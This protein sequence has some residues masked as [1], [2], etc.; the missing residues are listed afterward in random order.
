LP[1]DKNVKMKTV[2]GI[3]LTVSFISS[4]LLSYVFHNPWFFLIL[5]TNLPLLIRQRF[6]LYLEMLLLIIF[7]SATLK[8]MVSVFFKTGDNQRLFWEI[9]S[10][11][12]YA[13]YLLYALQV[14]YSKNFK[15]SFT[16]KIESEA[17]DS[18]WICAKCKSKVLF[19]AACWN[20]QTPKP[21]T[22]H[23]TPSGD[24]E[25]KVSPEESKLDSYLQKQRKEA[26]KKN[27]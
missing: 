11:S 3:M 1:E 14:V 21:G 8:L 13:G 6:S 12:F 17:G 24:P 23:D 26:E 2:I 27:G 9:G 16:Q 19:S 22:L 20:C 25:K 15:E 18:G 7:L 10:L 5:L 4:V